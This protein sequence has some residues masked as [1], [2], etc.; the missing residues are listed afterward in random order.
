MVNRESK[1]GTRG[2]P[3]KVEKN[4][5]WGRPLKVPLLQQVMETHNFLNII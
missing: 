4:G 2:S 5:T 1:N 3:L